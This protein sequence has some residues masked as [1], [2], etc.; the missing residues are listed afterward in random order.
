MTNPA[1][2]NNFLHDLLPLLSQECSGAFAE[3]L[4]VLLTKAMLLERSAV[5]DAKNPSAEPHLPT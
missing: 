3:I 4:Q 1:F 5:L 2:Q